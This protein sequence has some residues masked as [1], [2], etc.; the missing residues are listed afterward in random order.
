[1]CSQSAPCLTFNRAYRVASPGQVVEVAGGTYGDQTIASDSTKTSTTDV[2]FR[3]AAGT[4]VTTGWIR[5]QGSHLEL[6]DMRLTGGWP[7]LEATSTARDVTF[8]NLKAVRLGIL[9]NEVSVIG[10]EFG[11]IDNA[12]T[13][14]IAPSSPSA[15]Y[16]PTNILI[17][18]TSFHGARMTD[19]HTHVDCLHVWGING[20]TIR[21]SR[22]YDCEHFDILFTRDS[23]VGTPTNILIEN[24][25]F[26]CCRSGYFSVYLGDG[27]GEVWT[28]VT[29][30]N[31]SSNKAMGI[32][33]NNS[34]GPNV[35]FANNIAPSFDGCGRSGV[36]A[37][38][39]VW[40][41][42]SKCGTH[43]KVAASGFA[44][45]GALDFHL[46]AGA[47]AIDSGNPANFPALDIDGQS[48]PIGSAPDAG[49]D[50]RG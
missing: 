48:R 45:P 38:Y 19:G 39:N 9:G 34:T 2:V 26:D 1:M 5:V 44:N 3:P 42:G 33:P 17:D 4:T 12:S 11:P 49:A 30:R 35:V 23:V 29:V 18:G 50:E 40:Y 24:N 16:V 43:D 20:L 15:S 47:A 8:R 37:D 36:S 32:G 31:N 13:A 25:F 10:S 14:Q 7:G 27:D 41:A 21:N 6:R 28:N 22:F 46:T